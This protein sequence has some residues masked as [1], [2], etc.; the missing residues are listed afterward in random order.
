MEQLLWAKE[1]YCIATGFGINDS[2]KLEKRTQGK[3]WIPL[4]TWL[5]EGFKVE[6]VLTKL[7]R[8]MD[9]DS[10]A[11]NIIY[12]RKMQNGKKQAFII[13]ARFEFG[14]IMYTD[15]QVINSAVGKIRLYHE[16]INDSI[17]GEETEWGKKTKNF[18]ITNYIERSTD[19]YPKYI[20]MCY[21]EF[22]VRDGII[23][24]NSFEMISF[25]E[26]KKILA[27][28]QKL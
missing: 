13:E 26:T 12:T 21:D 10:I 22:F 17:T 4:P 15:F 5:P 7:G 14:D 28:L 9:I 27:S 23:E 24:T 19:D 20:Y 1:Q 8:N 2:I 25:D 18:A 16:P 6:R 3:S 11:L